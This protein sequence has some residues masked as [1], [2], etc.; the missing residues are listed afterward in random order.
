MAKKNLR[1]V[2]GGKILAWGVTDTLI[3][4]TPVIPPEYVRLNTILDDKNCASLV[5]VKVVH[6]LRRSFTPY[7]LKPVSIAAELREAQE[8]YKQ[9]EEAMETALEQVRHAY[10]C[11]SGC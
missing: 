3:Q 1:E 6:Y 11:R 5:Y 9:H 7:D 10:L 2:S 8:Y 4:E